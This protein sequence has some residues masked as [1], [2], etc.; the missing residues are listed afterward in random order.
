MEMTQIYIK[1]AYL[2]R[3]LDPGKI[4]YMCYLP[5]YGNSVKLTTILKLLRPLYRLK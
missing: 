1:S 5:S 2:N 4:I 3:E